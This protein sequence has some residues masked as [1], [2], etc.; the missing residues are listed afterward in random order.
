M[1]IHEEALFL[2]ARYL[3]ECTPCQ[4]A[5]G[6]LEA[7]LVRLYAASLSPRAHGVSCVGVACF[8]WLSTHVARD[9]APAQP[10]RD[11][12]TIFQCTTK[13][14]NDAFTAAVRREQWFA[15]S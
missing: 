8:A 13:Q 10:A 14:I 11:D 5:A 15:A 3:R 2:I 6:A 1:D 4:Q 12:I 7:E 9:T